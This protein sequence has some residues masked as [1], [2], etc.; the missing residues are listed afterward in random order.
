MLQNGSLA[1]PRKLANLS[2]SLRFHLQVWNLAHRC[3]MLRRTKK[4]LGGMA[5]TQQEVSHIG[6]YMRFC[7]FFAFYRP[8]TLTNS[9]SRFHQIDLKFGQDHL[10]TLRMKSYSNGEF[11]L[12]DLTVAW[13]RKSAFRQKT[14]SC[15]NFGIPFPICSKCH[16]YDK[17]PGLMTSTCK[18]WLSVIAPPSGNRKCHV[19]HVDVHL[20]R[21]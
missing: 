2:P 3:N 20:L 9:S 1:P 11:S 6:F 15:C 12:N 17:G 5:K 8:C 16:M 19:V 4:P 7:P 21:N 13:R 10:K 18:F 14:G